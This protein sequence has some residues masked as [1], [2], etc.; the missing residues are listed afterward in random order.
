MKKFFVCILLSLTTFSIFSQNKLDSLRSIINTTKQDTTKINALNKIALLLLKK[1]KQY[2]LDTIDIALKLSNQID[3]KQG[4]GEAYYN[5]A[6]YYYSTNNTQL[7]LQNFKLAYFYFN[8]INSDIQNKCLN[9]IAMMFYYEGNYD[10]SIFYYNIAIDNLL[11]NE[12]YSTLSQ[13]Y[14]NSAM[15]YNFQ[16]NYQRAVTNCI[17]GLKSM[18]KKKNKTF[19]DSILYG[20]LLAA[21]GNTYNDQQKPQE[22]EKYYLQALNFYQKIKN[23]TTTNYI[24]SIY[25]N[26]G[27][28]KEMTKQYQQAIEYYQ[29]ARNLYNEQ[30]EDIAYVDCNIAISYISL[31]EPDSVDKYVSEAEKFY[32]SNNSLKGIA[33]TQYIRGLYYNLIKNTK[34]AKIN[35]NLALENY[36]KLGEINKIQEITIELY[37]I[38]KKEKNFEKALQMHEKYLEAH[39][40]VFNSQNERK[41]TELSLT[42]QFEK[43][44]EKNKLKYDAEIKQRKA[45][46]TIT[47]VSLILSLIILVAFIFGFAQKRRRNK[48]LQVYNAQILQKNEEILVQKEEI[49]A[50]KN[51]IELQAKEIEKQRDLAIERGNEIAHKKEQIEAS[52]NYALRIQQAMLP[53]ENELTQYFSNSTIFYKPRDIVSGDFYWFY[54]NNNEIFFTA[55]DCTGHGVPGA[56]MS[57]LGISLLNQIVNEDTNLKPN[58]VLNK[59]RSAIIKSLKQTT[60]DNSNFDGIDMALVKYYKNTQI[61]EFS[62]AYNPLYIVSQNELKINENSKCSI[63]QFQQTKLY[64]FRADRMPIGIFVK[65]EKIFSLTTVQLNKNDKIFIFSDGFADMFNNKLQQKY[66]IKRFKDLLLQIYSTPIHQLNNIFEQTYTDWLQESIQTDDILIIGLEV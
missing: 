53:I 17:E 49:E 43:E 18:E 1:N 66:T 39:D 65:S 32:F 57:I 61:V 59:L 37:K 56:F 35:F 29:K 14:Y 33:K 44:T 23:S 25:E 58:D 46:Q 2:A 26:L 28:L 45:R 12:D 34:I 16:G 50:Q 52:I 24:A 64:D 22:S 20:N 4:I 41:I 7:A 63:S 21:I 31:N 6:I 48:E 62:G 51:Q 38:Y 30:S 13:I 19:A 9:N 54:S 11:K 47:L 5:Y 27:T 8:Q 10:S 42:Y 40:S 36:E 15:V 3:Y 55:A 60:N